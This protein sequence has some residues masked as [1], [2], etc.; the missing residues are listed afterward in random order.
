VN[1]KP[2]ARLIVVVATLGVLFSVS[3]AALPRDKPPPKPPN[4]NQP[5]KSD[6]PGMT[7]PG[8][9]APGRTTTIVDTTTT[10]TT[11]EDTT[12][13]TTV[14]VHHP[15][16]KP[17]HKTDPTTTTAAATTSIARA[18]STSATPTTAASTTTMATTTTMAAT[19]TTTTTMPPMD[20]SLMP[21]VVG[22]SP[23]SM[24]NLTQPYVID[25]QYPYQQ[26]D[27]T[28]AFRITAYYSNYGYADPIAYP[29]GMSPH[30]HIF[31]GNR[32]IASTT[33][34]PTTC[35]STTSDGG[36]LNKT[37]Y[38]VPAIIDS[39][40]QAVISPLMQVY[41]KTGY[42][43]VDPK[44]VKPFPAGLR[45]IAGDAKR[46][47]P[48]TAEPSY[49]RHIN[50]QCNNADGA[51]FNHIPSPLEASAGGCKAGTWF[52]VSIEFPQC[53]DGVHLDSADHHSHMA[54]ASGGCP[55]SHPVA[56]PE[57]TERAVYVV[58]PFGIP[59]GWRLASDNY[60]YNGS[61]AG[62]SGHGDWWNGWDTDTLN[63][64]ITGCEN[65]PRDC[66]MDLLGNGKQ[67]TIP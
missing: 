66:A 58:P 24:R 11:T 13:T 35:P 19:T 34:D 3:A 54:Y 43:G 65:V 28:G 63:Q 53:W 33:S 9:T 32:C 30:A 2:G 27:G 56:L 14:A 16:S 50:Y 39:T 1:T 46:T 8:K 42:K 4:P 21:K 10:T 5:V 45:M 61:N 47:T 38:W 31:Y 6:P 41:Y 64:W 57:I 59:D 7:A 49:N 36:T 12:T 52:V 37:G 26:S 17:P 22:W 67:L 20:M 40:G 15:D 60:A 55:A 51:E 29:G 48:D 25:Q 44:T 18:T 23:A 62:Y